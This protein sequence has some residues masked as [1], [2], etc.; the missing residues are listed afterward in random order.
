MNRHVNSLLLGGICLG[1]SIAAFA[2]DGLQGFD[3]NY[4]NTPAGDNP[5]GFTPD[6]SS[7]TIPPVVAQQLSVDGD[8]G[9]NKLLGSIDPLDQQQS[10]PV[11]DPI[12]GVE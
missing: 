7:L 3:Q 5:R 11:D 10:Q 12:P 6:V 1:L 2:Q 9:Q 8:R 4:P